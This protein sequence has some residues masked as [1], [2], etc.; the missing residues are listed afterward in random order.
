MLI[1]SSH[2]VCLFQSG[3][4]DILVQYLVVALCRLGE[5]DSVQGVYTWCRETLGRK[6]T[7]IKTAVEKAYGR[8]E[9]LELS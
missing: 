7:W 4:I 2:C 9:P 6:M 3:D 1:R 5:A 8:Y